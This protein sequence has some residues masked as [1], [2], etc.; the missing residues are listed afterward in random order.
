MQPCRNSPFRQDAV[1]QLLVMLLRANFKIVLWAAQNHGTAAA[2]ITTLLLPSTPA[3]HT[4][5]SVSAVSKNIA[6][7]PFSTHSAP[8]GR[9]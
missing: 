8:C 5:Y 4:A 1:R 2:C 6:C 7:R 9:A 3:M